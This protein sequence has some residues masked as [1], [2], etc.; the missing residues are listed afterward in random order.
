MPRLD[1]PL[2]YMV[3]WPC[4]IRVIKEAY[5]LKKRGGY[6]IKII[7]RD[8]PPFVRSLFDPKDIIEYRNWGFTDVADIKHYI[9]YL[10][11]QGLSSLLGDGLSRV[12]R[13]LPKADIYHIHNEPSQL[14]TTVR[15]TI[16]DARIIFDVH[17]LNVMRDGKLRGYE[18]QAFALTDAVVWI[19]DAY[20]E[21]A[22]RKYSYLGPS[23]VVQLAVPKDW[24][25]NPIKGS[26]IVFEGG[27]LSPKQLKDRRNLGYR[28]LTKIVLNF[29]RKNL[30]IHMHITDWRAIEYYRSIGAE[31]E[32]TL[33]YLALL[34][35]LSRYEWGLALF[36]STED[37]IRMNMPNKLFDYMAAGIPI[38]ANKDTA[39]GDF[40]EATGI[41]ITM[42]VNSIPDLP[43]ATP[44]KRKVLEMRKNYSMD[45]EANKIEK[46][47]RTILAK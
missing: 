32:P 44:Y 30:T 4:C 46:L 23:T 16:P 21:T 12:L 8:V 26:G 20:G 37:Q 29:K 2:I 28:D 11:H 47:Y 35:A 19:S 18:Q 6:R 1:K 40:V 39:F 13:R 7:T 43:D 45:K 17:D 27:A 10:R 14:V 31:I 34:S 5:V 9:L 15:K 36:D 41:G 24:F 25:Q 33:P 22:R 38:I 42:D 3:T